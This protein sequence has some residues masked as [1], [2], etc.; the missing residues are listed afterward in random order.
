MFHCSNGDPMN[1]HAL[2]SSS[3]VFAVIAGCGPVDPDARTQNA[4][5]V[6]ADLTPFVWWDPHGQVIRFD[7]AAASNSLSSERVAVGVDFEKLNATAVSSGDVSVKSDAVNGP[8]LSPEDA[9]DGPVPSWLTPMSV[10]TLNALAK[11]LGDIE[12]GCGE[13]PTWQRGYQTESDA[14]AALEDAGF[15]PTMQPGGACGLLGANRY[16]QDGRD[17][18][19]PLYL[20]T[21]YGF[22]V[23]CYRYQGRIGQ[24]EDGTWGYAVQ[25]APTG[26]T[27]G[28]REPNPE[29]CEYFWPTWWWGAYAVYYHRVRC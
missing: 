19:K 18:T 25:G 15:R 12:G 7:V 11:A 13:F 21:A 6:V 26:G 5:S 2:L 29:I 10:G 20:C 8:G 23:P 28:V 27:A 16:G 1:N 9:W 3:V 24:A 22:Q 4:D 14:G 17:F